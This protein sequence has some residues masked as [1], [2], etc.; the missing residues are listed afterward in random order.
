MSDDGKPAS[1][2]EA[3]QHYER[4]TRNRPAPPNEEIVPKRAFRDPRFNQKLEESQFNP[5]QQRYSDP[6]RE[7]HLQA[8]E[9]SLDEAR[10]MNTTQP[11]KVYQ[12]PYNIITGQVRNGPHGHFSDAPPSASRA[13]PRAEL[14][15][16]PRDPTPT[17]KVY[18]PTHGNP[19]A[20][21]RGYDM[22][23][24]RYTIKDH[25][26][27]VQAERRAQL[28][29]AQSKLVSP[30]IHGQDAFNPLTALYSN[31][32]V[33]QKKVAELQTHTAEHRVQA[34]KRMPPKTRISEG[35]LY[36]IL[37]L[38]PNEVFLPEQKRQAELKG[39]DPEP[40]LG[41]IHDQFVRDRDFKEQDTAV[42]RANARINSQ[43][44]E[45]RLQRGYDITSCEPIQGSPSRPQQL[46]KTQDLAATQPILCPPQ[47]AE[48]P[49]RRASNVGSN[50]PSRRVSN[51]LQHGE[52]AANVFIEGA[53]RRSSASSTRSDGKFRPVRVTQYIPVVKEQTHARE[54]S[55]APSN[56][57]GL[58][59]N[60]LVF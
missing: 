10:K 54:A 48:E 40:T 56:R 36:N 4:D 25:E 19:F 31:H 23:T 1:W 6:G 47:A 38:K 11:V 50:V 59:H 43:R 15:A 57:S 37:S 21:I 39:R 9:R 12:T 49:L 29:K 55:A 46:S 22:I 44:W 2:A 14:F 8:K 30:N 27:A 16:Y 41:M 52:E 60:P 17:K 28:D 34:L 18:S 3:M 35:M 13:P 20:K 51:S 42:K 33:E 32:D 24:N 53:S 45:H 5:I 26:G 58:L 7:A